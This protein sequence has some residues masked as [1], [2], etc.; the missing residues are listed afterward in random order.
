MM[1]ENFIERVNIRSFSEADLE[2]IVE[3]DLKVLGK[4]R[5][6]YWKQQIGLSNAH[7]PLSCLVAELEG[8]VSQLK[9]K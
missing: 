7:Y 4:D 8:K 1:E 2:A 6:N 5:L 9:K 3:I